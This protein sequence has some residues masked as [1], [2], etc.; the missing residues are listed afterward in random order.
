MKN[1]KTQALTSFLAPTR[2]VKRNGL[3][4]P[5][6]GSLLAISAANAQ[7]LSRV[8]G[9]YLRASAG[10]TFASNVDIARTY[11]PSVVFLNPPP[12][13]FDVETSSGLSAGAA[14]GY[15]FGGIFRAELAYRHLRVGVDQVAALDG[16]DPSTGGVPA[17]LPVDDGGY[18][19]HAVLANAVV[20][21]RVAFGPFRPFVSAGAGAAHVYERGGFTSGLVGDRADWAPAF[22]GKAGLM[23]AISDTASVS[24]DYSYLRTLDLQFGA[25]G[26]PDPGGATFGEELNGLGVSTV[27]LSFIKRF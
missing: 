19:V 6:V 18:G 27:S 17:L 21:P 25:D 8:S 10:V 16:F 7:P 23:A 2:Q 11:D 12:T 9:P 22:Q 3:L 15:E 20:A 1:A 5:L 14:F 4:W 26:F 24:I 13:T